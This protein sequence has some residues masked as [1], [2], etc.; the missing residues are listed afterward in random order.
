MG[1]GHPFDMFL[2]R[3]ITRPGGL[4]SS[5]DGDYP[6]EGVESHWASAFIFFVLYLGFVLVVLLLLIN[7]LIAMMSSSYDKGRDTATLQWRVQFSRLVLRYELLNLPLAIINPKKHEQRCMVGDHLNA[8]QSYESLSYD[9]TATLNLDRVGGDLFDDGGDDD[10]ADG[11][12]GGEASNK[13]ADMTE[14]QLDEKLA[15]QL[16]QLEK[17]LEKWQPTGKRQPPPEV[18]LP[19]PTVTTAAQVKLQPEWAE[20]RQK[21]QASQLFA[22]GTLRAAEDLAHRSPQRPGLLPPLGAPANGLLA[23]GL[24]AAAAL[25]PPPVPQRGRA[26]SLGSDDWPSSMAGE[27]LMGHRPIGGAP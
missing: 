16:K 3:L 5:F 21:E 11:E 9:K 19:G 10:G 13:V 18:P 1:G 7:L 2:D 15:S 8:K 14:K 6:P 12:G 20:D 4:R 22:S 27:Q 17:M 24:P 25:P 26:P 23:N